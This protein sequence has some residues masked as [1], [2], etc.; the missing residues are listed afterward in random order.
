VKV[1]T[2]T[3]HA[4]DHR[5]PGLAVDPEGRR[6]FVVAPRVVAKVDLASLRV[7]YHELG[8]REPAAVA[9]TS[10]GFW[11]RAQWLGGGLL[12]V[13]GSDSTSMR[14]QPAGLL[15]V[16][17]RTWRVRT[18]DRGASAFVLEGGLLLATGSGGFAGYD[19]DGAKRFALFDGL[20]AFVAEV[21]R[22]RAYVW[23]TRAGGPQEPLRIVDLAS[24][25]VVGERGAPLPRLLD[26]IAG[27]WWE[28]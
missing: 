2:T 21:Y 5:S 3:R 22:G 25:Q 12:A 19:L 4:V 20:Q 17:T 1:L 13:S 26:G 8:S 15:V 23:V 6:A 9:K 27:S 18:L 24:G 16:D 11:R 7:S 14:T 28:G 10:T